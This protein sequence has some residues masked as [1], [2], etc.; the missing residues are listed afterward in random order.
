MSCLVKI[1]AFQDELSPNERKIA[2][3]ILNN[4]ALIRDY[5]SQNLANSVGVSQ[6]SI[7]KFSQKLGYQGFPD[8]KLAIHEAVLLGADT[9][10]GSEPEQLAERAAASIQDQLYQI[11][12]EAIR[13]TIELND[14]D[15]LLAAVDVLEHCE[16]IQIIALGAGSMAARNFAAMLIQIGK[17]V[18][19]EV[20]TYIQLSSVATLGKGDV[21]FLISFSG[22]SPRMLEI[23]KR[24]KKAGATLITLTNYNANPVRSLA[25]VQLYSVARVGEY[26]LPQIVSS[27]SQQFVVDLLFSQLVRR[28]P[29]AQELVTLSRRAVEKL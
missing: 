18:I 5:S 16:R 21:A 12:S 10:G 26:E 9:N 25:D 7:V 28:S 24:A 27:T 22:Q 19:A 20:D 17:S 6:S 1:R 11:K 23:V 14:E 3:F 29:R 8:L 2:R 15:R 13:N 4:P